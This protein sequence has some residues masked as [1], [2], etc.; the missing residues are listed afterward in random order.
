[1]IEIR[2]VAPPA[3]P[4]ADAVAVLVGPDP[5]AARRAGGLGGAALDAGLRAE[6]A[7]FLADVDGAGAAGRV[8]VLPRPGRRPGRVYTVGVGDGGPAA[9]RRAAAMLVRAAGRHRRVLALLPADLDPDGLRAAV[10]GAGLGS[11]RYRLSPSA[12]RPALARLDLAVPDP[13]RPGYAAALGRGSATAAA[14]HLARDL[15]NTPPSE[16]TPGWLAAQAQRR[17]APLGV[18]VSIRDID[19]LTRNRFGGV[20]A[21]GGGSA[22]G[23]RLITAE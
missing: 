7:A 15:V 12:G 4:T 20:L 14:V 11:Y 21:V 19:W 2:L 22:R 17:L 1:M 23:P 3:R 9:L 8:E 6:L 16:K 5:D 18:R 13:D 10:E